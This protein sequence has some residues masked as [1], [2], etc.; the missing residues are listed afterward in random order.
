MAI[1]EVI[2]R[3]LRTIK[4]NRD[5]KIAGASLR[6]IADLYHHHP[7]ARF[8]NSFKLKRMVKSGAWTQLSFGDR[9]I[10]RIFYICTEKG[11]HGTTIIKLPRGDNLH[12]CDFIAS[13]STPES[14]TEYKRLILSI[15]NDPD[16]GKHC[17]EVLEFSSDGGYKSEYIDGFNLALMKDESFDLSEFTKNNIENIAA[18]LEKLL[19]SLHQYT[20]RHGHL[21]GDW[22]LHNLM[23]SPQR[24]EIFNVDLEG[25]YSFREPS[26]ENNLEY[27]EANFRNIIDSLRNRENFT[28][29]HPIN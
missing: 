1:R 14:L 6:I 16:L 10:Q 17:P 12:S 20:E 15:T 11:P 21:L 23:Y 28:E 24:G 4:N 2:K 26:I 13:L 19:A 18:A 7:S 9:I 29:G 27:I 22:P 3:Q 5:F 25:F 8:F